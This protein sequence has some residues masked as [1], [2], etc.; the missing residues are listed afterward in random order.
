MKKLF[1]KVGKKRESNSLVG[2]VVLVGQFSVKVEAVIGEGGFATIY[3]CVNMKSGHIFA[4]KHM[5]LGADADAIKEV[6][7]EAKTM[8][9][10]KGHPNILRLHAVAFAGP[11]GS[12]TDG[13]MLLDYCPQTLLEVMQRANFTLDDYLV[14]EVFQDV[15]WA[16]AHMHKCN[17]P[18]AHRDLKAENVLKNSEGRWVICDFGSSTAR[19]QV[20]D[21]PTEI[22][23]EEENIRR[24]TT[25]AY[26]APEMWD[27]YSR[28]RI[29]TAVD[30]WALG[31]LLYVLAFGKLPFQGDSKLSILYGKYDMP[32]G[33]P[34]A[35]RALIQDMLQVNPNDRPDV[36]QVISKLDVL[37]QALSAD[38]TGDAPALPSHPYPPGPPQPV[39]RQHS[40]IA[41]GGTLPPPP[42]QQ[43]QQQQLQLQ[44]IQP[45]TANGQPATSG[46][47]GMSAPPTSRSHSS[48]L[49]GSL[50]EVPLRDLTPLSRH[51]RGP[52]PGHQECR[53]P[54]P[55]Q[56][57]LPDLMDAAIQEPVPA[58]MTAD[59]DW[60]RDFRRSGSGA[61]LPGGH[62]KQ[63]TPTA[64]AMAGGPASA[65]YSRS[66]QLHPQSPV[67]PAVKRTGSSSEGPFRAAQK[68]QA[69]AAAGTLGASTAASHAAI[70]FGEDNVDWDE[71]PVF[72][73]TASRQQLQLQQRSDSQLLPALDNSFAAP[74]AG[75]SAG[76]G[77]GANT[78]GAFRISS[79]TPQSADY[80]RSGCSN[81]TS[82]FSPIAAP[83]LPPGVVRAAP[84]AVL[85]PTH[86][87]VS[88]V[89]AAP[90][91]GTVPDVPAM[92]AATPSAV[93][94]VGSFELVTGEL[95]EPE[96]LR[97]QLQNLTSAN[98]H[99][100]A[101]V[102]QL[103]SLVS[104]QAPGSASV[105]D[106]A[107]GAT[108]AGAAA[109]GG[110]ALASGLFS[111]SGGGVLESPARPVG[112]QVFETEPW[113]PRGDP[114]VSG[115]AIYPP[116]R[117]EDLA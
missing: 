50:T 56:P 103:E 109:G 83:A 105:R 31:V 75:G 64:A 97:T 4:L 71:Q 39:Q 42:L 28:Q 67:E 78:P 7:Q 43:Q 41:G 77:G 86:G 23:M 85:P 87:F 117:Y 66:V 18:L 104:S 114:S 22:A 35:M 36:F 8:A 89:A 59:S 70:G 52:A 101:R 34:A 90:L 84:A 13:F 20:Y 112:P 111:G 91:S 49:L 26:R 58:A 19:A 108:G 81:I 94:R 1:D 102:R 45:P 95:V 93:Q 37:R 30:V 53:G 16:V 11:A 106:E 54:S 92:A 63:D 98:Q 5:R 88:C 17:P 100:E 40:P 82:Q 76:G 3:K 48:N 14:Y 9:R 12:E 38:P 21:T 72:G 55:A 2:K 68:Q 25:P 79:P 62:Q 44:R 27:L 96:S 107:W 80:P 10:L 29:D 73:W 15:V 74:I 60:E 57:Q 69:A 115:T 110:S 33:R 24:T 61:G 6:Q 46:P 51:N 47:N 113:G 116:I 32:P 65:A 99:L